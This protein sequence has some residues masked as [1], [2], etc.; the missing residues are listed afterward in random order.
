MGDFIEKTI[1]EI[2]Q[3]AADEKVIMGLSG[4][5][6]SA[7]AAVLIH[8][9][10]GDNLHCVFVNNGLKKKRGERGQRYIQKTPGF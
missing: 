8:E 2:K 9:A 4:G 7:V 1:S 6:D 10:I 5:V 3:Q